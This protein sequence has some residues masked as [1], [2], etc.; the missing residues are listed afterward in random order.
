VEIK[1]TGI[2]IDPKNHDLI[3][4]KFFRVSDPGLHSTGATKFMGAG[5]GL[6]L[7]IARGV[8]EGHG[9]RIWV[10]SSGYDQE[11]LPGSTFFIVLP[12]SPPED[13]KRVMPFEGLVQP[14][15]AAATNQRPN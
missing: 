13:A 9:G 7:T 14:V 12:V 2:G 6:G 8:I 5:P 1:D 4:E 11:K 10:E 3:F 15:P